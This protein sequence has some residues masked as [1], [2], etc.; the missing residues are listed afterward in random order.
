MPRLKTGYELDRRVFPKSADRPSRGGVFYGCVASNPAAVV[1]RKR[2]ASLR[3]AGGLLL[4]AVALAGCVPDAVVPRPALDVPDSYRYAGPKG[5]L[6]DHATDWWTSFHSPELTRLMEETEVENLDIAAAIGQVEQADAT[7]RQSGAA[8]FPT[9]SASDTVTRSLSS[10]GIV[11]SSGGSGLTSSSSTVTTSSGAGT[12]AGT[13]GTMGTGTGAGTG[14]GTTTGATGTGTTTTTSTTSSSALLGTSANTPT[15]I[16]NASFAASYQLDLFGRNRA[17]YKSAQDAAT[18]SRWNRQTVQLTSLA[19]TASTYLTI[20]AN[21]ERI[22]FARQD[23]KDS[24]G[25][26]QLIKTRQSA[27]TATDLD[28]AQQAALVANLKASIPPLEVVVNQN[29]AALA[30]LLGEPPERV[31]VRGASVLK[32]FVPSIAPGIPSEVL[33]LR[34]DVEM[35]EATLAS[36]HANLVAARAAFFPTINLTAQGGFESLALKTLF[37]PASTFYSIAGNLAQ[38]IFD[39][40]LLQGEFDLVKGEQDTYLANYRKAVITA[41]SDVD[42]ALTALKLYARQEALT[43]ESLMASRRA[44]DLSKQRLQ[45][46]V[47]DVVTL[48]QTEQTLFTTQDTLVQVRLL[49]LMEAVA[50]Y[51]ALGGAYAGGVKGGT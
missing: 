6:R 38:P 1:M 25:I 21:R 43:R 36:A 2:D 23:V 18:A 41:F 11:T 48:L 34:P 20:V 7:A 35:A 16:L 31:Q 10:S 29:I 12:G 3:G 37:S 26:L 13:P 17:L 27:G 19:S 5:G 49:R 15:T 44:Y 33:T 51:Q 42:K 9:L 45:Q 4:A 14:V 30:I 32:A 46:G 39:G 40:G 8:L 50:L 22:A 24:D 28:V 47:L